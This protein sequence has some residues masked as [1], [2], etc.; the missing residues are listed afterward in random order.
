MQTDKAGTVARF[1]KIFGN[2]ILG[3]LLG[4]G[5]G[6]HALPPQTPS[7]KT[8]SHP[9]GVFRWPAPDFLATGVFPPARPRH[10]AEAAS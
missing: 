2:E 1:P 5:L 9:G 7:Q 8:P 4:W 10:L 3:R 6:G